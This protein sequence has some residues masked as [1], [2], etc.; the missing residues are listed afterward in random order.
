MLLNWDAANELAVSR[1]A[2]SN[3]VGCAAGRF[4]SARSG[5]P[6]VI[7][8][9]GKRPEG[10]DPHRDSRQDAG[11]TRQPCDLYQFLRYHQ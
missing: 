2:E 5:A 9:D 6:P 10:E 11:A 4:S 8:V 1:K 3:G 7:S